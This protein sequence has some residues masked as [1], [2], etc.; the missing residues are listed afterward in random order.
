MKLCNDTITVFNA[1]VDAETGGNVWTPTVITGAS[2]YM[3]DASTIDAGKGGL[4]AANKATIRIPAPA[5]TTKAYADPI[6]YRAAQ[7][8]A[9]LWTLQQGDIIVHAD[10]PLAIYTEQWG[11]IITT[12]I[13]WT[14]VQLQKEYAGCVTVLGVTDNTRN[15]A[16]TAGASAS[17]TAHE[18]AP[19]APHWRVTGT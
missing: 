13:V 2:W 11:F 16:R 9:N 1:G 4:V 15:R 8:V 3:T 12:P 19:N 17:R 18:M 5:G 14:P 10:V 7:S 6:A